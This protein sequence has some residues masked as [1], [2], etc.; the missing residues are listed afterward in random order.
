MTE[1]LRRESARWSLDS[2][3]GRPGALAIFSIL[4]EVDAAIARMGLRPVAVGAVTLRRIP[5]IDEVLIARWSV[6]SASFMPHGGIASIQAMADALEAAGVQRDTTPRPGESYPEAR[7][8]IEAQMLESL[9]HAASPAAVDLL[10]DQ[11]RRWALA[12]ATADP[13][14]DRILRRLLIPPLVVAIGPANIGK[15]TLCN[16]LAAQMVSGVSEEPGTTRDAVGVLLDLHGVVVKYL[17]TPGIRVSASV[18]ERQA[19]DLALSYA[20]HADLLLLCGDPTAPPPEP[21]EILPG[22]AR[23]LDSGAVSILRICL[24]ADRGEPMFEPDLSVSVHRGVGVDS[25]AARIRQTLVPD[26]MIRHPGPWRFWSTEQD[27]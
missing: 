11:P 18:D 8:E 25:L 23:R 17:D 2:P 26:E 3:A 16:A 5:G 10:L 21:Q 19:I 14:R 27:A 22:I 24:R 20:D 15:S 13:T 7:N 4:G 12:A 9:V 1:S 6:G